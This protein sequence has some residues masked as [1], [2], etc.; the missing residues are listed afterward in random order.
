MKNWVVGENK[1][2]SVEICKAEVWW[3]SKPD[4]G[5]YAYEKIIILEKPQN[6]FCFL[7]FFGL[8][9]QLSEP[10]YKTLL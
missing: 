10:V 1:A 3:G 6:N 2:T 8:Q 7:F 4:R 9:K 5:V